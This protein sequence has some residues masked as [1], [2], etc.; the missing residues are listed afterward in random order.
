M[1]AAPGAI[2][3]VKI[4]KDGSI[5][6]H[7]IGDKPASG[8][9]GSGILDILAELYRANII[10]ERG[11]LNPNKPGV[12]QQSEKLPEFVLAAARNGRHE[13]AVA[14]EDIDQVLLAKGAIRAG[15]NILMNALNVKP[16]QIDEV[17][18]A[19]AFGTYLDPY[20]AVRI[21]LLPQLPLNRIQAVGN[22]A[23]AGA[24]MLL[25]STEVRSRAANLAK[26]IEYLDLTV[27]P[28]FNKYFA[29]GVRL[30]SF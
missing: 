7:V 5:R 30:P 29:H 24:R 9:C 11:R 14:Q 1:R 27:H 19:G 16:D 22:A 10:N 8:I 21:G 20:N 23:G 15:I 3:R 25:A 12:R 13:I 4:G 26:R 6:F 18:I 2:E 17:V 28:G